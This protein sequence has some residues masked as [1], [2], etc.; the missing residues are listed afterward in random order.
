MMVDITKR[1]RTD[2]TQEVLATYMQGEPEFNRSK[3]FGHEY[4][5]SLET[6][7]GGLMDTKEIIA[8]MFWKDYLAMCD[9]EAENWSQVQILSDFLIWIDQRK[10]GC[11]LIDLRLVKDPMAQDAVDQLRW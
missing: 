9:G 11:N 6:T 5:I 7:M 10:T 3:R 2:N 8:E 4:I 1:R